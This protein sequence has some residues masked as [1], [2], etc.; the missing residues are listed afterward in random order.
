MFHKLS[1][2]S[3]KYYLRNNFLICHAD[4]SSNKTRIKYIGTINK[5][6]YYD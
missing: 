3:L 4:V 1:K 2:L 5:L 6:N